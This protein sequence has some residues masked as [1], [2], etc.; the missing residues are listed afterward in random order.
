VQDKNSM[1]RTNCKTKL[2]SRGMKIGRIH[3]LIRLIFISILVYI[4][5]VSC[6]TA[7][8]AFD[9]KDV[10][11]LYNPIKNSINPRYNI[12]N[13]ADDQSILSVKFFASELLFTEAN[14]QVTPSAMILVTVKLFDIN[15]GRMLADTAQYNLT[16]IKEVGKKE[17]IYSI[18][19][20]V[21]PGTE[22][23]AEVKILDRLRAKVIQSFIPFNTLSDK[24]RYNFRVQGH[25]QKNE[26]FNPVI[27]VDEFI[28]LVYLK[29]PADSL[30]I[31]Y[32][33]PYRVN[34]DP[35]SMVLPEKTIDY[36]PDTIVAIQYSDTLP[37]M[38]P[39][40]G[41]YLC[42]VDR[43]SEEGYTL[44]NFGATFPELTSPEVMMEPLG[45]LASEAEMNDML[46]SPKPKVALDEFWI[47]CGGNVEKARELIRI[48]YTRVLYANYYFTSYKEG[49]RTERGMIYIIYGPPDKV[50]KTSEGESW[51]YRKSEVKSSWGSRYTVKEDYLFF[52]FKKKQSIFTD[53]D[54]YLS[55]SE[56][57]ITFWDRA[58]QNWRKGIV[59][60][61]DN[62]DEI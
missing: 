32:Y 8:V 4:S 19:L 44:F 46:T 25:F 40:T 30:F 45:Y 37:I 48:Y 10:S 2:M 55:R 35:P 23:L 54:Y 52:N 12:I 56:S 21:K 9:S 22:Y 1:E 39:K 34:P 62:P 31:S 28:N 17:Y 5:A 58:V 61:L 20:K 53:N 27:R 41:I 51:G 43:E 11:Y 3:G 59:F 49:W 13:P 7:E 26:L 42:R 38:F 14:P 60:R 50:Y 57:N 47:E 29:G 24:S 18:P 36:G 6:K 16:I 15:Q 33:K